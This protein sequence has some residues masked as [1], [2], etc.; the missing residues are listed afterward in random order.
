MPATDISCMIFY[1]KNLTVSIVSSVLAALLLP[2]LP[3]LML[4]LAPSL[5]YFFTFS[6]IDLFVGGSFSGNHLL[7]SSI[8][9]R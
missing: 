9:S 5:L 7:K 4:R 1:K 8:T 3:L 2:H 6:R